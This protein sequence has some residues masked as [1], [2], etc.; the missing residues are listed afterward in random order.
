MSDWKLIKEFFRKDSEWLT[1]T[2]EHWLSDTGDELEYWRIEKADSVIV[3]P[4]QSGR[5]LCI[6][7]AFRVG[8]QRSTLDFPGGRLPAG[9]QP[10]DV[11]SSILENELGVPVSALGE[12]KN[13]NETSWDINSSFSSQGLWGFVADI[14]SSFEIPETYEGESFAVTEAG[15]SA[16]L[17]KLNCLQCRAVLL[18]WQR[19]QGAQ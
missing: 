19:Q 18:E 9:K 12:V 8:V 15:I 11:V 10:D 3:L 1:L 5:L 17:S 14:D 2:G 4:I 16:L 7:P 13:L 6:K